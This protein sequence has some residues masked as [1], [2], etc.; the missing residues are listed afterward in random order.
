MKTIYLVEDLEFRD[1]FEG[2]S[3]YKVG[4]TKRHLLSRIRGLQNW[5]N[6]KVL[7]STT[8]EEIGEDELRVKLKN[9]VNGFKCFSGWKYV[10]SV[11]RSLNPKIAEYLEIK[12]I[13]EKD[14]QFG[15]FGG[16]LTEYI[17]GKNW[18]YSCWGSFRGDIDRY[19]ES[20]NGIEENELI[21]EYRSA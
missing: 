19:L 3:L 4:Y 9:T 5:K 18:E 13:P 12:Y 2:L 16:G 15:K 7:Y 21:E 8:D 6:L 17:I 20:K 11:I 1:K 10:D 14:T